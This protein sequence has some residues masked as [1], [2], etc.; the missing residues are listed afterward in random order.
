MKN[1]K[2]YARLMILSIL[3]MVHVSIYVVVSNNTDYEIPEEIIAEK[4]EDTVVAA[5]YQKTTTKT[6]LSNMQYNFMYLDYETIDETDFNIKKDEIIEEQDILYE[7]IYPYDMYVIASALNV[8]TSPNKDSYDNI[9]GQLKYGKLV[10]VLG[11][12]DEWVA[13]NYE[14]NICFISSDYLQE[15]EPEKDTYNSN[16]NGIK[17][18]KT[19][20]R[21][22]GPSGVE[23]YYNLPMNGVIKL[24]N[25]KG[26]YGNVWVRSDGVKMWDDYVMV[27]ADLNVYP[28]GT[29]VETS[30]GY[31]IVVDTGDFTSNGSGV[32]FD[33]AVDW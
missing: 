9:V 3:I 26:F 29:I 32:I 30:L 15:T 31:G 23:T 16:W 11:I 7:Y 18:N 2:N 6:T 22:E 12:R 1:L 24:M 27:A 33:I 21:I 28:K 19:N 25:S 20:G 13:I 5:S 17:L 14:N 10:T 8:R 4:V